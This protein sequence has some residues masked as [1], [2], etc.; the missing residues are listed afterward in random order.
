MDVSKLIVEVRETG[1]GWL[2]SFTRWDDTVEF[3]FARAGSAISMVKKVMTG[4]E[5]PFKGEK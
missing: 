4:Q 5:N 2:V 3:V 1:N